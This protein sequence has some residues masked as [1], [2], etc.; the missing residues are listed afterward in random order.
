[1]AL[2]REA[3]QYH[4]FQLWAL[5]TVCLMRIAD[6]NDGGWCERALRDA[7][8]S[9]YGSGRCVSVGH[10]TAGSRFSADADLEPAGRAAEWWTRSIG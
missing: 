10:R 1:M 5:H 4:S 2:W 9:R 8:G 7:A 3:H 6:K